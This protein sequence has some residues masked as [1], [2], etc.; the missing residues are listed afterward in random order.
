MTASLLKENVVDFNKPDSNELD[1][2][3]K[4]M[5]KLWF[6]NINNEKNSTKKKKINNQ[7]NLRLQ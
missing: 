4:N 6:A 1:E 2:K 3:Q 5:N 7:E